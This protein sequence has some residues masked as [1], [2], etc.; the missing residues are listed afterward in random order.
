MKRI[1]PYWWTHTIHRNRTCL[2]WISDPC[3]WPDLTFGTGEFQ[4]LA[5]CMIKSDDS[6]I[7]SGN[8]QLPLMDT[9]VSLKAACPHAASFPMKQAFPPL[10]TSPIDETVTG[11]LAE[12]KPL[13]SDKI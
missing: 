11:F 1:K 12:D 9:L 6:I 2:R 5:S 7:P 8:N 4:Y 13:I 10:F 3:I